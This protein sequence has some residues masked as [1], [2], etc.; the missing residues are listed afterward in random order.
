[1]SDKS[2]WIL[3]SSLLQIFGLLHWTHA[4]Y[5][6]QWLFCDESWET[7][8]GILFEKLIVAQ[9]LGQWHVFDETWCCGAVYKIW[10]RF[11]TR[12][13]RQSE[14]KWSRYRPGVAQSVVRGI[15]LLFH[16]R[17]TRRGWVVSST[18]RPRNLPPGK[19]RYPL[20]RNLGGP[21]GRSGGAENLVRTGIRPR[22]VQPVVSCCTDWTT[23]ST[24]SKALC[25]N[26]F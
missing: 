7:Y 24:L 19:T 12:V 20:Y 8:R 18:P 6:Q 17:G 9:V 22:T 21:Q 25:L 1:M 23:R 11:S 10:R 3:I 16:D 4:K 14:V 13:A 2:C 5:T 15:A 26:S